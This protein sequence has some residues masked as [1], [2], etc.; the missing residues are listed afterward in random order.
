MCFQV[1]IFI[2]T[3]HFC[4][5]HFNVEFVN[6][7][8]YRHSQSHPHVDTIR[9]MDLNVYS[10]FGFNFGCFYLVFVNNCILFQV[11]VP[12]L[13]Q[14]LQI[15]GWGASIHRNY[16][17]NMGG[18]GD[19][20]KRAILKIL[21]LCFLYYTKSILFIGKKLEMGVS[22]QPAYRKWSTVQ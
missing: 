16:T 13:E 21:F 3:H 17:I 22:T 9:C 5:Q 11:A 19:Y 7:D 2:F 4:G 20:Q 12:H 18:G 1:E 6:V 14:F 10:T 15:K 8:T